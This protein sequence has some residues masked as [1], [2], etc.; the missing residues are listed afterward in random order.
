MGVGDK[1]GH[2]T[3][4]ATNPISTRKYLWWTRWFWRL[5]DSPS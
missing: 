4:A 3:I 1:V 5:A 2:R